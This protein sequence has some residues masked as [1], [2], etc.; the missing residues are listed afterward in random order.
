MT[1]LHFFRF[2]RFFE[3]LEVPKSQYLDKYKNQMFQRNLLILSLNHPQKV[4]LNHQEY[5]PSFPSSQ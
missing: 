1:S 2:I 4:T 5:V 3:P